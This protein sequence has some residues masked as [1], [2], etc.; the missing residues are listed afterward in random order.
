MHYVF[1]KIN[2]GCLKHN[3]LYLG[4]MLPPGGLQ[5]LISLKK[6]YGSEGLSLRVLLP[7][8]GVMAG[9]EE[10]LGEPVT[11]TS[12]FLLSLLDLVL[13]EKKKYK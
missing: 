6:L 11:S 2:Y 8:A 5:S 13:L 1:G 3:S 10:S 4:L 9:S 12:T 7:P